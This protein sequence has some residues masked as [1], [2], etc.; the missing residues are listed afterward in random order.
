MRT[1]SRPFFLWRDLKRAENQMPFSDDLQLTVLSNL[2]ARPFL[3][4]VF[5]APERFRFEFLDKGLQG[6][7]TTGAFI[8]EMSPDINFSYLPRSMGDE[9]RGM[10]PIPS[11]GLMHIAASTGDSSSA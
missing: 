4:R 10:S 2:P 3:L 11:S 1:C 7:L 9:V 6:A 8:D 5:S